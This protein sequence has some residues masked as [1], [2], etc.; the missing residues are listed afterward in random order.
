MQAAEE[1]EEKGRGQMRTPRGNAPPSLVTRKIK[2]THA[3][4]IRGPTTNTYF[5]L[6]VI[7][8]TAAV[9]P[10]PRVA[11]AVSPSASTSRAR[12]RGQKSLQTLPS[13]TSSKS[14][15]SS[16]LPQLS[17][18]PMSTLWQPPCVPLEHRWR[19]IRKEEFGLV[20]SPRGTEAMA[21]NHA[22]R[23]EPSALR[24]LAEE[25]SLL[26]THSPCR[27]RPQSSSTDRPEEE[28]AT[29][30]IQ[31]MRLRTW[32]LRRGWLE[33]MLQDDDGVGDT[34]TEE[35]SPA[36]DPSP[37]GNADGTVRPTPPVFLGIKSAPAMNAASEGTAATTTTTGAMILAADGDG[38]DVSGKNA[39]RGGNIPGG[40]RL[41][42]PPPPP[43]HSTA[44]ETA[45]GKTPRP[46]STIAVAA[47][48]LRDKLLTASFQRMVND[49]AETHAYT[50]EEQVALFRHAHIFRELPL[51]SRYHEMHPICDLRPASEDFLPVKDFNA[52][53][54]ENKSTAFRQ[55]RQ[56][57][58]QQNECATTGL[59]G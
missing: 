41:S 34:G 27:R 40:R 30:Q 48:R 22:S 33:E 3:Y 32:G 29:Q 58:Q 39:A 18:P 9:P 13:Q 46:V 14:S 51:Q 37:L 23:N 1:K 2:Q 24:R 42:I 52:A 56:R 8:D 19:F 6:R 50:P 31:D 20:R 53:A 4:T 59:L 44:T 16:V 38:D 15:P 47:Q 28:L 45:D 57:R 10:L 25:H 5:T 43:P 36:T 26:S 54:R 11:A 17:S 21:I 55:R 12:A 7:A 49:L 35:T